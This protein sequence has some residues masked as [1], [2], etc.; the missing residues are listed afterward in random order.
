MRSAFTRLAWQLR[1]FVST[2]AENFEFGR[3]KEHTLRDL[4]W[5]NEHFKVA[6]ALARSKAFTEKYGDVWAQVSR[7]ET[8]LVERLQGY[9]IRRQKLAARAQFNLEWIHRKKQ[10]PV[11]EA[12]GEIAKEKAQQEA[13]YAAQLVRLGEELGLL[14]EFLY[15]G[16]ENVLFKPTKKDG[17]Y[18]TTRELEAASQPALRKRLTQT[19]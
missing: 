18:V 7:C 16:V 9:Y 13:Q 10:A 11:A 8:A 15:R 3:Q 6:E 4:V 12:D 14:E 1:K 2:L 19:L 17:Y 5:K